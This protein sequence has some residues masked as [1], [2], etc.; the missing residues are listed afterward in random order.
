MDK[1]TITAGDF[2]VLHSTVDRTTRQKIN[3]N[4]ELNTVN[5]QDLIKMYRVLHSTT[6]EYTFL[7]CP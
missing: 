4:I 1:S 2:N 7:K 3:K 6:V 5:Q